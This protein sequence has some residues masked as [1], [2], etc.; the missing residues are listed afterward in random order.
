M[1]IPSQQNPEIDSSAVLSLKILLYC[2]LIQICFE[3]T[4]VHIRKH[5]KYLTSH[6]KGSSPFIIRP[7]YLYILYRGRTGNVRVFKRFEGFIYTAIEHR[8]DGGVQGGK[9]VPGKNPNRKQS[10]FL[11]PLLSLESN[12]R[13]FALVYGRNQ[14]GPV[15]RIR[16]CEN[17]L[18]R[19]P[20]TRKIFDDV[21]GMC[22]LL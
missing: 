18:F 22:A 10:E 7:V 14:R 5:I 11:R 21:F 16:Q 8:R 12:K 20:I 1:N 2:K 3:Q 4:Q 19:L 9:L 15:L 6:T 17:G 13:V